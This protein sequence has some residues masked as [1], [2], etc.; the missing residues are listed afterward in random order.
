MEIEK[1]LSAI[2]KRC[3][4]GKT[5]VDEAGRG[6]GEQAQAAQARLALQARGDV[7]GQGDALVGGAQDELAGVEDEGFVGADVH[8]VGEL[9]LLDRGVDDRVAMIV[10]QA[11]PAVQPHID[12]RRLNHLRVVGIQAHTTGADLGTD[13]AVG[14]EHGPIVHGTH[15]GE[16]LGTPTV[17][18]N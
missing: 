2:K 12:G 6:V 14:E 13:V 18:Y 15:R 16:E 17:N 7:V 1:Y 10:E 9:G 5:G 3:L 8:Q 11:E 4:T